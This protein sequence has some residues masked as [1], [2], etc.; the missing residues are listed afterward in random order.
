MTP[1]RDGWWSVGDLTVLH[2]VD[3]DGRSSCGL[4]VR[5]FRSWT[6]E[7]EKTKGKSKCRACRMIE[8]RASEVVMDPNANLDEQRELARRFVEE[9]ISL[10]EVDRLAELVL[11]LDE[12]LARG[13]FLPKRWER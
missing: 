4:V 12:W 10:A 6:R 5:P 8:M 1:L 9:T 7:G 11:A 13:G 2:R 3:V